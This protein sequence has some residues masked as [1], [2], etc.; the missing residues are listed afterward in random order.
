MATLEEKKKKLSEWKKQLKD[1]EKKKDESEKKV[2][3]LTAAEPYIKDL[4][5]LKK[6]LSKANA[7]MT[8]LEDKYDNIINS[9]S[10]KKK[11]IESIEE[12]KKRLNNELKKQNDELVDKLNELESKMIKDSSAYLI[13]CEKVENSLNKANET[14]N[15]NQ[16][17]EIDGLIL[18]SEKLDAEISEWNPIDESA[19]MPILN[20][21][22]KTEQNLKEAS[23]QLKHVNDAQEAMVEEKE[24]L[25]NEKAVQSKTINAITDDLT[26]AN[27]EVQLYFDNSG[28]GMITTL[29]DLKKATTSAKSAKT[30]SENAFSK[31]QADITALEAD[32]VNEEQAAQA[33]A[34][35]NNSIT[36]SELNNELIELLKLISDE[37]V[38]PAAFNMSSLVPKLKAGVKYDDL[39]Y[40]VKAQYDVI[41]AKSQ[42]IANYASGI[43]GGA[44]ILSVHGDE[45][46]V[47]SVTIKGINKSKIDV[48]KNVLKAVNTIGNFKAP[49]TAPTKVNVIETI[50]NFENKIRQLAS[51]DPS[52]SGDIIGLNGFDLGQPEPIVFK[53][54]ASFEANLTASQKNTIKKALAIMVANPSSKSLPV[55]FIKADDG[56][57][58]IP[59][60]DLTFENGKKLCP[61]FQAVSSMNLTQPETAKKKFNPES[62]HGLPKYTASYREFNNWLR[63]LSNPSMQSVSDLEKWA[64]ECDEEMKDCIC[65]FNM[66]LQRGSGAI[67]Q[68]DQLKK[69]DIF[70]D[71]G[72]MSTTYSSNAGFGGSVM[73]FIRVK[74]GSH[75]SYATQYS[76]FPNEQE[77]VLP[78]CSAFKIIEIDD[79][80]YPK[81]IYM[82]LLQ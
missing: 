35:S 67:P 66:I 13:E 4:E 60:A 49:T 5:A 65:P 17:I 27:D 23:E 64:K 34:S 7:Q 12:S 50:S 10:V 41:S 40:N 43:L 39:P 26:L 31:L 68:F 74:K 73:L 55:K 14:L 24:N 36:S 32:I 69:G 56:T 33:A 61:A 21:I 16:N 59:L 58:F 45:I 62:L 57:D 29:Q 46:W 79:T 9:I 52:F 19:V 81:K 3:I 37:G 70:V 71:Q 76:A 28:L 82:E 8:D 30:K 63:N 47:D 1:I 53:R 51:S 75:V 6:D 15:N 77:I 38:D 22:S 18:E 2:N 78:R 42:E 72:V 20:S 80:S 11:E 54:D 48:V 25:E 44:G